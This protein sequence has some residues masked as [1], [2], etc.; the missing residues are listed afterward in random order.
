MWSREIWP[1]Y[2]A[3]FRHQVDVMVAMLLKGIDP[4]REFYFY[5]DDPEE[6]LVTAREIVAGA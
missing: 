2:R 3:S 1:F 6:M 5:H 4:E